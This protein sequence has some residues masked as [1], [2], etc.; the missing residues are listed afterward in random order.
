LDIRQLR[1]LVA[2]ARER[3]FARAAEACGI[4]QPTLSAA[5]KQLEADLGA[6]VVERGNRFKGLTPEGERVLAWAQRILADCDALQQE[7]AA[8]RGG[9]E[10]RLTIGVI[11]T[12]L[13]LAAR[14]TASVREA[15]PGV[16]FGVVSRTSAEIQRG[17]DGFELHAGL[18]YL[19]NEP[20]VRVRAKKLGEERYVL[21]APAGGTLRAPV[22]WA[23][24]AGLPLCLLVPE[25]QNRRIVD[26][27]FRA[28]GRAPRPVVETDAMTALLAHVRHAGLHAVAPEGL[29]E[30]I[31]A[32]GAGIAALP[33]VEPEVSHAVG[34]VVADRSPLPLLVEA[35]WERAGAVPR[36]A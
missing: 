12:A 1:Y 8:A 17:L 19:E 18:T 26:A 5:L 10:G 32:A 7:L 6:P 23:E 28:A 11:P 2:L 20:L 25:M 3:H 13:P 24:A 22:P 4:A 35:L 30:R 33:L 36:G 31:G 15:H 14:L 16:A 21:L 29:L 27:A 34:L 9:L